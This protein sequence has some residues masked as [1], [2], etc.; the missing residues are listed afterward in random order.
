MWLQ[1]GPRVL[2][3][4]APTGTADPF[5]FDIKDDEAFIGLVEDVGAAMGLLVT[6]E[7]Y[8][9]GAVARFRPWDSRQVSRVED[10]PGREPPLVE[11]GGRRLLREALLN[12]E[13]PDEGWTMGQLEARA[14][15][16]NGSLNAILPG[17]IA[18]DLLRLAEGGR[19]HATCEL[20]PIAKPLRMLVLSAKS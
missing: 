20:A 18:L 17:A 12:D 3:A 19:W 13:Q 4:D 10:L 5:L 7:G 2:K 16:G 6:T 9:A 11:S 15:L 8:T 14:G 1:D